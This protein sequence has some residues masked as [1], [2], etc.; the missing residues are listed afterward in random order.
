L[1][2]QVKYYRNELEKRGEDGSFEQI[3]SINPNFN[4]LK[5][6]A[7]R[8][9]RSSST[10]LLTG[11]SGVGKDMFARAIHAA[12]PRARRPFVK[13]NCAAIPEALLESELFGYAPGSFTGASKKGKPGYFEQ[14]QG[15]T[16]FLDE[17][18]D[19]PLPIQVKLLQVL[20]EK[21]FIR[22]GGTGTQKVDVRIIAATNRDL[23]DAITR[24]V[25]RED[26]YYRLH[27]I[28]FRLPPLRDHSEDILPLAETFIEKYNHILGANVT[29]MNQAARDILTQHDWPGNIRELE[30]AVERAANW[31]WEGEIGTEHLPPELFPSVK[32]PLASYRTTL[33]EMDQEILLET[34]KRAGGNKSQ[35][36]RLLNLSRSA[37]YYKLAKYGLH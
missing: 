36:A 31:V 24:G 17:I 9:A 25:F 37:F 11:E 10:V 4:K 20:Q 19:M 29:G 12:S 15:G 33:K 16:I 30:N 1:R 3:V 8:I 27:V 14:A 35:A 6:D 22:V 34:L 26:I 28:E 5:K 23:R 2:Q 32:K 18:G 7:Q 21:Q 13:V